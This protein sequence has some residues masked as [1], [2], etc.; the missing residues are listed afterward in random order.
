MA[1]IHVD[2]Q[3]NLRELTPIWAVVQDNDASDI[4]S[5]MK[6]HVAMLHIP[7]MHMQ[8]S[9][10]YCITH[11]TAGTLSL[12]DTQELNLVHGKRYERLVRYKF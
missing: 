1:G 2:A 3:S 7:C 5:F 8:C 11:L 9:Y 12:N 4:F 10:M 6:I